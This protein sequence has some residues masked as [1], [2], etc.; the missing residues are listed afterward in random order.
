MGIGQSLVGYRRTIEL[1]TDK[2]LE[3][4]GSPDVIAVDFI[5][6]YHRPDFVVQGQ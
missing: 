2:L 1:R 5:V 6:F 4:W 3:Q